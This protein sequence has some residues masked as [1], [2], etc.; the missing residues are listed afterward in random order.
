MNLKLLKFK[1][2]RDD[3]QPEIGPEGARKF[4]FNKSKAALVVA[5]ILGL[6]G[7]ITANN[8]ID[9]RIS[10]MEAELRAKNEMVQ[11]VVP[12]RDILRGERISASAMAI[13]EIPIAYIDRGAVTPERFDTAIGQTVTHDVQE[14]RPLMWAHLR[15]G[16]VPSFSGLLPDGKRAL[17]VVVDEV[18]AVSGMLEPRDRIDLLLTISSGEKNITLPLLQNV[19]VMATGK[20]VHTSTQEDSEMGG[21]Q[22]STVTIEVKPDEAKLVV[23]AQEEGKLTAVLRHPQDLE[24]GSKERVTRATLLSK[25]RVKKSSYVPIITGDS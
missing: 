22:F 16:E 13:R 6:I 7:V 11:V 25:G 9:G 10:T 15:G 18:N 21:M 20:K 23:L 3:D 19:Q 24:P 17:T 4:T 8:W 5:I 2:N 12:T 14:G 1:K